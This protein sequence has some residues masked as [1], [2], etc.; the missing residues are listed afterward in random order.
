[1]IFTMWRT[2]ML[3]PNSPRVKTTDTE[4]QK[5]LYRP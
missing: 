1:M 3:G 5:N 2:E 4:L